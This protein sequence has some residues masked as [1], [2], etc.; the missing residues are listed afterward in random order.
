MGFAVS[1]VPEPARFRSAENHWPG[2]F[3]QL[4][5]A[6]SFAGGRRGL[7]FKGLSGTGPPNTTRGSPNNQRRDIL[8]GGSNLL[9]DPSPA[10]ERIMNKATDRIVGLLYEIDR[11]TGWTK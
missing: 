10:P 1:L 6:G 8:P 4:P 11:I 5:K 3:G 7:P 9:P 2:V